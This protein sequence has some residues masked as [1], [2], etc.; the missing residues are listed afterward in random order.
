MVTQQVLLREKYQNGLHLFS[1]TLVGGSGFELRTIFVAGN[2]ISDVA[3]YLDEA[4]ETSVHATKIEA[5][6][7]CIAITTNGAR[8]VNR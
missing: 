8:D 2:S 6:S 1:V 3:D 7:D 5:V 4:L